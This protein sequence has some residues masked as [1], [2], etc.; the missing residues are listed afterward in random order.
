M[1]RERIEEEGKKRGEVKDGKENEIR[2]M[3]ELEKE[4]VQW[5]YSADGLAESALSKKVSE[6]LAP[7]EAK[8]RWALPVASD[9]HRRNLKPLSTRSAK[10]RDAEKTMIEARRHLVG[11]RDVEQPQIEDEQAEEKDE[12]LRGIYLES[13]DVILGILTRGI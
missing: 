5:S 9:W 2:N 3:I 13:E 12:K 10:E 11:F 6:L 7:V 4:D 8:R 1:V